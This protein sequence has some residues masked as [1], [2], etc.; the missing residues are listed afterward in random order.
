MGGRWLQNIHNERLASKIFFLN[1]LAQRVDVSR[2]GLFVFLFCF[3]YSWW[4]V[5]KIHFGGK[6][7]FVCYVLIVWFSGG[8][9]T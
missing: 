7:Y 2:R 6:I 1:D 8:F 5:T 9:V 4:D 3:K